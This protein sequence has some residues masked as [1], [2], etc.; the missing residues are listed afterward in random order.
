MTIFN[1]KLLEHLRYMNYEFQAIN[2]F[3]YRYVVAKY[4]MLTES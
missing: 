3:S 1:P 4:Q 2:I